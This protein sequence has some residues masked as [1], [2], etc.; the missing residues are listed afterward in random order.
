VFQQRSRAYLFLL[1][2]AA[3]VTL[4]AA[5]ATSAA[6]PPKKRSPKLVAPAA[7]VAAAK[8]EGSVTWY[9]TAIVD[10][11]Q[12]LAN[13]FQKQYGIK[14]N[15]QTF[16]AGALVTRTLAE[17]QSNNVQ[18][19]VFQITDRDSF[20]R[21]ADQNGF[22]TLTNLPMWQTYPKGFK[23][24]YFGIVS[25]LR[26]EVGYNTQRLS[27]APTNWQQIIDPKYRGQ[28]VILDPRASTSTLWFFVNL[29]RKLGDDFLKKLAANQPQVVASGNVAAPLVASGEKVFGFPLV[30]G[31]FPGFK[32]QNAPLGEAK[33]VPATAIDHY[34]AVMRQAPHPNAAR[35]FLNYFLSNTG[36]A[37]FN[38]SGY[39]T[40]PVTGIR[41][42]LPIP[43]GVPI[44]AGTPSADVRSHILSLLDLR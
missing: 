38:G 37:S 13:A 14:V 2:C 20:N 29:Q 31:T 35:L 9:V 26:Y 34:A 15:F 17:I 3:L 12:R 42:M 7:L 43:K 27:S 33:L 11:A 40:S 19:D 21:V 8:K 41:G 1:G 25:L 18:G 32:K 23:Y 30:S 16:T 22:A 5:A 4:V 10:Q 36:Q 44:Y 24:K 28:I 6:T 39:A